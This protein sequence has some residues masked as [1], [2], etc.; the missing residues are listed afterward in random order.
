MRTNVVKY[1]PNIRSDMRQENNHHRQIRKNLRLN[2]GALVQANDV[3]RLVL[4]EKLCEYMKSTQAVTGLG[5][6]VGSFRHG[7]E[8]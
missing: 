1:Q 4:I 2:F 8:Q 6:V 5:P 3:F 7:N